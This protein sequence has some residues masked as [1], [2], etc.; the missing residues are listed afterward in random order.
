MC[1]ALESYKK[2]TAFIIKSE[3]E[4]VND[5][6][7]CPKPVFM[8]APA[9]ALSKGYICGENNELEVC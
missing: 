3:L 5:A 6:L 8:Q 2:I 7:E 4:K 9:H 1:S